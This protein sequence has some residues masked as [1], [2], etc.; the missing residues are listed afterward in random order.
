MDWD[1]LI[2]VLS[3]SVRDD[4]TRSEIYKKLFDLVGTHD[5]SDSEGQDDVFDKALGQYV[6]DDEEEEL[7]EDEGD[8]FDYDDDE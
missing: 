7:D 4:N 2:E 6:W 8:G 5:A 3:E 1:A